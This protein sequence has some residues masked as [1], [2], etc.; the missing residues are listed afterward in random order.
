MP[1]AGPNKKE[2]RS[3]SLCGDGPS[4]ARGR[5]HLAAK[6][7]KRK[8]VLRVPRQRSFFEGGCRNDEGVRSLWRAV[9]RGAR[10]GETSR[11]RLDPSAPPLARSREKESNG[12]AARQSHGTEM[13]LERECPSSSAPRR[14]ARAARP[15]SSR[16]HRAARGTRSRGSRRRPPSGTRARRAR[17]GPRPRGDRARCGR[18]WSC[19]P[20]TSRSRRARP[21]RAARAR[22]SARRT[23]RYIRRGESGARLVTESE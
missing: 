17:L 12:E 9:T 14:R 10:A 18:G 21:R 15:R 3:L 20:G 1:D 19:R 5:P 8:P 4:G 11:P 6:H 2:P 16:R 7:D 23:S 13:S 22:A